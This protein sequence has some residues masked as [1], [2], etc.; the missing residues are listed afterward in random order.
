MVFTGI[1]GANDLAGSG[2]TLVEIQTATV[3]ACVP[4]FRDE[5]DYEG[6]PTALQFIIVAKEIVWK[7]EG[8]L[9]IEATKQCSVRF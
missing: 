1:F 9:V 5:V 3:L 6:D 8:K 7:R 4:V 2:S